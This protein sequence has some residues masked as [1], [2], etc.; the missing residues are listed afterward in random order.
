MAAGNAGVGKGSGASNRR[1]IMNRR[2]IPAALAVASLCLAF[3]SPA[4]A[5]KYVASR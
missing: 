3:A 5:T 4:L 1:N 2:R